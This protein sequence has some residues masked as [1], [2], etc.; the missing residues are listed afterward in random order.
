[1]ER[2]LQASSELATEVDLGAD[3]MMIVV[4]VGV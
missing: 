3:Y 1:M 4:S 2:E